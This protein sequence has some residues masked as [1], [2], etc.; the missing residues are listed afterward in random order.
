MESKIEIE[1]QKVKELY[2]TLTEVSNPSRDKI[3]SE[4]KKCFGEDIFKFSPVERIKTFEDA[5]NELGMQHPFVKSYCG[6]MSNIHDEGLND[7]DLIAFLKLRIVVAA[8][9][10]GWEPQFKKDEYRYYP[11]VFLYTQ[12][13]IKDMDMDERKERNLHISNVGDYAGFAFADSDYAPSYTYAF[14]GS[15]LC[16]KNSELATYCGKQFITLWK[17]FGF[18]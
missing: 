10:E 3:E 16:L 5:K 7:A 6:Y 14:I 15:R 18:K 11:W 8:L 9:N 13:E 17:D 12:E 2:K 4:M 1:K